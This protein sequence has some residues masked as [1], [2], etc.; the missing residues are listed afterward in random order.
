MVL[1]LNAPK[2]YDPK[3]IITNA[4]A[5]IAVNFSRP[6]GENK[7]SNAAVMRTKAANEYDAN[8]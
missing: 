4:D 6:L 5:I 2:P 1:K 3:A 8:P 7:I